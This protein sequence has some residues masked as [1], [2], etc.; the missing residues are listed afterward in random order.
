MSTSNK[1]REVILYARIPVTVTGTLTDT[2]VAEN[3][4]YAIGSWLA[5][6]QDENERDFGPGG[7]HV[8]DSAMEICLA[9]GQAQAPTG[10]S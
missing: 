7:Y 9:G 6:G 4:G 8:E 10:I 2:E 1:A 3:A 5:D